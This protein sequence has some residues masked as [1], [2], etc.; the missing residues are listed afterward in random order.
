MDMAELSEELAGA[1]KALDTPTVCNALEVVDPS[2]RARGFNIKPLVCAH[3]ELPPIVG[4]ARTVR[5]RA[6]HKP[7]KPQDSVGYYTYV[8]EGG[9]SPS[10]VVVQDLDENPGFGALWGEVNT[11]VHYGLGCIGLVT[12]G[13]I[14]DL[15]DSQEKFQMLAGMV[16]PSHAWVH[17]VDWG[18]TVN[19]HGMEVNEKDL[20]HADQ[21]GS[22]VIPLESAQ[23]VVEEA[24]KIM[25]RERI[26]INAAKEPGFNIEKM[27][28]AWAGMAE[29]H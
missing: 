29:I 20:I 22:V 25:A 2:R 27:K 21:H 12:N 13:S 8:A 1:L 15:P 6:T 9:P 5:M 7:E 19:V 28:K 11:N 23:H 16:N 26:L 3:P 18:C 24:E 14:R 17:V 10:I 4:F